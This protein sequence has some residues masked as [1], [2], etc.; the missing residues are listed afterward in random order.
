[1]QIAMQPCRL[2]S[3]QARKMP[4]W[5]ETCIPRLVTLFT[6]APLQKK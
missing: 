1:M 3:L 5:Q 6:L 4:P 2:I